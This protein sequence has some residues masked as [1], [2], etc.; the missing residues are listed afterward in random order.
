MAKKTAKTPEQYGAGQI[1]VLKGLE[2]VR[3]RPGMYIGSTG[4]RGLHHL[5]WE[6]VDNAVDEAMAGFCTNIEVVVHPDGSISVEDNGRGI[7]V[8]IHPEEKKP[9]VEVALTVLHAGGKFD[10]STYKV[11]GGLHGVGVSVVNALSEWMVVIVNRDG[12]SHRIEFSRGVVTAPLKVIGKTKRRGTLVHF[13]PD[14]T[15]FD[16]VDFDFHTISTR[17][18]QMAYLNPGLHFRLVDRR[19]GQERSAEFH[20]KKG[21]AEMVQAI[22]EGK[23]PLH[24]VVLFSGAAEG[25]QVDIAFQYN[26][27][28][29]E[30]FYSFVNSIRTPGGGTHETGF[31]T[32]LTNC[33]TAYLEENGTPQQKK[34]SIQGADLKE[35]LVAVV[36][37]RVPEPQFE[38]QTKDKLGN[39]D[40]RWIVQSIAAEKLKEV[41]EQKPR[42]AR[43]ILEKAIMAARGR[44]AARKAREIARGQKNLLEA[45]VLAGKLADCSSNDPEINELYL[46]EGDSAGGTAKMGRDRRFQAI[47][48]LRG[49]ILN[50]E[51]ASLEKILDNE[52]IR[53][54]ITALGCG[55]RDDFNIS[56]LRYHKVVIMTDADVDG[57]H[58][59]TLLLTLFFRHFRPLIEAGHI[60]IAQPPLY[61]VRCGKKERYAY[62]DN[63]RDQIIKEFSANGERGSIVVQ[64]YKGLGEMSSDQLWSTTMNP[65]SRILVRVEL[66][67][68][69]EADRIFTLLMGDEVAPR[70]DWIMENATFANL[71][72]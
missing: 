13:R 40:V 18:R 60:Y 67:D 59:R 33:V 22:S 58:I 6:V 39:S 70:R 27:G 12:K 62:S 42:I 8:D 17:L 14:P 49:K 1:T 71:D 44:E 61:L 57:A 11:A 5:V 3:K 51:R 24:D 66:D 55:F 34:V 16:T 69:M 21:I 52:E 37:V 64:R 25:V 45:G 50:T 15:I 20:S 68:A 10:G 31:R 28:Y 54:I 7:P 26:S 56:K 47:L 53:R 48:P 63:E 72:L 30:D 35:G 65:E 23:G 32:A 2:A 36:S 46:V 4:E 19:G 38:G 43:A 9:G 29:N 41:F